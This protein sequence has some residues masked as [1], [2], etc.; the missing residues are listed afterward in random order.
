MFERRKERFMQ[1]WEAVLA[2][3]RD[4]FPR[5]PAPGP[6]LPGRPWT[7]AL[8]LAACLVPRAVA[9]WN[10]DVLWGDSL[11]YR[12]ASIALEQGNF[13]LG[14]AEFGLNIYPLILIPL[15]HLGIDWEIAGKSFGV[16][17]ASLAV[18]PLWGWLR[19]M[20]D[21]RLA[22]IACL[23]YALHGK[24]IAI[25]PLILRDST[26]WLLLALVLYY[27]WRAVGELRIRFFLAAGAALTLA[28]HTRTEGWLLVIPLLGW[29]ACR[30]SSAAGKRARLA[31]GI[32]LCLGVIPA[33]MTAVNATWLRA[34]P[35]WELLRTTHLQM[36]VDWWNS[37]SGMNVPGPRPEDAA[38]N[39][40]NVPP[41]HESVGNGL[42]PVP[43][44]SVPPSPERDG[45]ETLQIPPEQSTPGWLL[46]FKFLERLAKGCTWIGSFLLLVGLACGWR[47][48]LRPEHLTLFCMNLLL[49]AISRIRYWT[50]GLDLRYFMPMVI[51]G[52]PWM[53]LGLQHVLAA[54]RLLFEKRGKLSPRALKILAGSLI[55]VGV[56][57]S[58]LDGPM[59]AA[60]YMR[61]HAALGRW[62]GQHAG[63][64]RAV[65]GSLN[66]LALDTFYA[67]G[68]VVGTFQ[69]RDCLAATM[70]AAVAGRRAD[71]VVLW[72]EENFAPEYLAR[73]DERITRYGYRRVDAKQLPAGENELL[74]F[75]RE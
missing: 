37:A 1:A 10:W 17:V 2:S 53:A 73:I 66:H 31:V 38:P 36:A 42:R 4:D 26:F 74:V 67:K 20:F 43:S 22:V 52:V 7:V 13:D 54:A 55:A 5:G 72:N 27:V 14:F 34:H 69:P 21:D 29:G 57:C 59:S 25:S 60:A 64:E 46:T 62:V 15:R 40:Y 58:F 24:L 71:I 16:L 39:P 8:L 33:A 48:F 45:A 9:A 28:V 56:T 12:F 70:P 51:V 44:A 32:L 3:P 49:L 23:V 61:K 19:R 30:W 63:P 47:I 41:P 75:L 65:A 6:A 11:H 18:L 35:R 68:H 50:G